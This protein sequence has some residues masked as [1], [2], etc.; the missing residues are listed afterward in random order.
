MSSIP[1]PSGTINMPQQ[2]V[3]D[4]K[5]QLT[6]EAAANGGRMSASEM[7][8]VMAAQALLD[9]RAMPSIIL[10]GEMGTGKTDTIQTLLCDATSNPTAR[11]FNFKGPSMS[12]IEKVVLL[13]AEAGF[14]DVLGHIPPSKLAWKYIPVTEGTFDGLIYMAK[15]IN[16]QKP[17]AIQAMGGINRH[18]YPQFDQILGTCNNFVDDRTGD[19]LGAVFKFPQNWC[20]WLESISALT[21]IV[22]NC[23]VGDKPYY[24]LR[25][26]QT[27]QNATKKFLHH[28]VFSTQC[29]FVATAHLERETNESNGMSELMISTFGRKLAPIIPRFFSDVIVTDRIDP[30]GIIGTV[31]PEFTWATVKQ[32]V[33]TKTRNLPW[34]T[35]TTPDFRPLLENFRKR[36]AQAKAGLA[37]QQPQ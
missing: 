24:E 33:R 36:Q 26:Y 4:V 17:E 2:I 9:A 20:L 37:M 30:T 11:I 25:D 3:G 14:E 16:T 23:A 8:D 28:L 27:V 7:R 34:T 32:G 29:L 31:K 19:N 15:L 5:D 10:E 18:L 21:E 35:K 12:G 22:K 1:S 6:A 13:T